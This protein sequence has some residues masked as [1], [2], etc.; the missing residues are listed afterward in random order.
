MCLHKNRNL[1]DA[2][3]KREETLLAHCLHNCIALTTEVKVPF[4]HICALADP[5]VAALQKYLR[6]WGW[7][8]LSPLLLSPCIF[9]QNQL[10]LAWEK[11]TDMPLKNQHL[12][13]LPSELF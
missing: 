5:E 6:N 12:L 4:G 3:E 11:I 10:L 9:Y 8:A 2:F 1:K 13:P 7:S